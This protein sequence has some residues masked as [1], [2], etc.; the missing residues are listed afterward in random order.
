MGRS[1]QCTVQISLAFSPD[2]N[3]IY[4]HKAVNATTGQRRS[5][6]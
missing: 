2:R 4:F 1:F 6:L 5:A 3:Y